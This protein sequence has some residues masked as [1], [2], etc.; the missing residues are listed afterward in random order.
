[1]KQGRISVYSTYRRQAQTLYGSR[2][3]GP[4]QIRE[5]LQCIDGSTAILMNLRS[6]PKWDKPCEMADLM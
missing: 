5:M 6:F 4:V 2:K 3:H 1:M